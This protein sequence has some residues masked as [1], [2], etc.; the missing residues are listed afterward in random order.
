MRKRAP[1]CNQSEGEEF[2]PVHRTCVPHGKV[3]LDQLR[4]LVG[5]EVE[6]DEQP[7]LAD[8]WLREADGT[9]SFQKKEPSESEKETAKQIAWEL[10]AQSNKGQKK[11]LLS[12]RFVCEYLHYVRR[13]GHLTHKIARLC[14]TTPTKVKR[15]IAEHPLG[16]DFAKAVEQAEEEYRQDIIHTLLARAVD[17]HPEPIFNKQGEQI[18]ERRRFPEAMALRILERMDPAYRQKGEMD[19]NVKKTT[20]VLVVQNPSDSIEAWRRLAASAK[21]SAEDEK[22]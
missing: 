20:G 1:V 19:V 13:F 5:L 6:A 10:Y 8:D 22:K 21:T 12:P 18:G 7:T 17:G 9:I 3:V 2:C 4:E 14:R 15:F 16:P 11:G